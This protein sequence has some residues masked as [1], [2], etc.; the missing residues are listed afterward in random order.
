MTALEQLSD[1]EMN[2]NSLASGWFDTE[3]GE[4]HGYQDEE[5]F[6]Q[7][8][9]VLMRH[10]KPHEE[11]PDPGLSPEGRREA[12]EVVQDFQG[13][14]LSHFVC[15]CSPMLRCLETARIIQRGTGARFAVD[16][17]LVEPPPFLQSG[18][19][20][21]IP[22]RQEQFAEFEW[23]YRGT[24]PIEWIARQDFQR[25]VGNVLR[26]LPHRTMIISHSSF[27]VTMARLALCESTVHKCG[28]PTA[29]ITHIVN[30]EVRCLGR[31]AV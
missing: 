19:R 7:K 12:E 22:C 13:F 15:K 14:D 18:D 25:H 28:I 4:F 3:T 16:P 8:E 6:Y 21:H 20:Y 26:F 24:W 1:D 11:G 9:L 17:Y 31:V 23:T 2:D 29:S 10:A 27:V 5:H 30:K